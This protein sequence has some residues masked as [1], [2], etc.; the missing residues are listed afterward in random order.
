MIF[1]HFKAELQLLCVIIFFKNIPKFRFF[2]M[3]S[4]YILIPK[5]YHPICIYQN[6]LNFAK[7]TNFFLYTIMNLDI[8]LKA[9]FWN[10]FKKNNYA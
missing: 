4:F 10:I 7:R 3:A 1:A 9:K 6:D 5:F 2:I 8:P